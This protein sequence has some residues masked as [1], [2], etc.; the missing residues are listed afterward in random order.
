MRRAALIAAVAVLAVPAPAAAG[1]ITVTREKRID[2]RLVEYGLRTPAL[3]KETNLRVLLPDSYA[4]HPRKRYPVLY[5]LHGC[6][7]YD[8]DGSQAWTTHGEV[9]K[10]TAH[11]DL[12]VV[13]PAGGRGGWYTDWYNGGAGGP[14]EYE[15]YHVRQLIPWV[16]AHLRT[17]A[18]RGGRAIA[19]LS[20]GGFGAMSYAARH[21]DLFVA[22][23]A[24]SGAVHINDP[25]YNGEVDGLGNQDGAAP[26]TIFGPRETETVRWRA[27]N[28]VDL[29][30]NLRGLRLALRTGN[31]Q[32]GGTYGGGPD[33]LEMGVHA[34]MTT[35]HETL[36]M[37]H[38][39]HVWD[40]YGPGAHTW[41]YWARDL[42]H[43]LP[44]IMRAFAKPPAAPARVR[45][46][47]VEPSYGVYG[48]RVRVERPVLEFSRLANAGMRGFTLTGS[49]TAVVRTPVFYRP[50]Q[51]IQ[52]R[53]RGRATRARAG[54]GGRLLLRFR[55]GPPNDAQQD[56]PGAVTKVYTAKVSIK[57]L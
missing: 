10:A 17:R 42:R 16:D 2:S 45:F 35:L 34:Q 39:P 8:V 47:A 1:P 27:H 32:P 18:K 22:A 15:T 19:G 46:S 54:K 43:T 29:A 26:G 48:W 40:D 4:K 30:G 25:I 14:P 44:Q 24:F 9:E 51:R 53:R 28:P 5:L 12:I 13:M 41:P 7:D 37:L 57:P 55:L 49:G 38:F 52:V 31:G 36:A 21:P 50:W 56:R 6:C 23:A 11:R 33:V 20:M 3:P